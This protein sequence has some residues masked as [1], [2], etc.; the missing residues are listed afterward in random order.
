MRGFAILKAFGM[1]EISI[2]FLK[3]LGSHDATFRTFCEERNIERV[4]EDILKEKRRLELENKNRVREWERILSDITQSKRKIAE[5]NEEI[6]KLIEASHVSNDEYEEIIAVSD[7]L[8]RH[9]LLEEFVAEHTHRIKG[10][11]LSTKNIDKVVHHLTT[12]DEMLGMRKTFALDR[13]NILE[14]LSL[15]FIENK[16]VQNAL[17]QQICNETAGLVDEEFKEQQTDSSI[18]LKKH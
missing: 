15:L 18:F 2:G 13:T 6:K 12:Q 5:L 7:S 11:L 8:R 9:E 17:M 4:R 1:D 10:V 3:E 14:A 16:E